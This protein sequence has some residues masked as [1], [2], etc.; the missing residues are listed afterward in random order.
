MSG[1]ICHLKR[2]QTVSAVIHTVI[3]AIKTYLLLL[4]F[5]DYGFELSLSKPEPGMC[6]ADFWFNPK[7]P[8]EDCITG[9]SYKSSTG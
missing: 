9:Q 8:P 2:I 7:A 3:C 5:S 6:F 4:F 1:K